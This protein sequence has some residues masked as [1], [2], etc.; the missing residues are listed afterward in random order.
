MQVCDLGLRSRHRGTCLLVVGVPQGTA[1]GTPPAPHGSD[2]EHPA[3]PSTL[4]LFTGLLLPF[5]VFLFST[6]GV[7]RPFFMVFSLRSHQCAA[8]PS[9]AALGLLEPTLPSMAQPGLSS[10]SPQRPWQHLGTGTQHSKASPSAGH[11]CYTMHG[12]LYFQVTST[13]GD[14]WRSLPA[15]SK[16]PT[17]QSGTTQ[18]ASRAPGTLW[19][20]RTR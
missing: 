2:Y 16:H 5:P 9:C 6:S 1:Q 8:G 12:V 15:P 4:L 3:P 17:G 19:P 13:V 18:Q 14:D 20:P 10:Q 11:P 7:L